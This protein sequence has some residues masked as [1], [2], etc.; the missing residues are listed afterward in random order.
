MTARARPPAVR[1]PKPPAL[2]WPGFA[3]CDGV[4][5]QAHLALEHA[6][7]HG[8]E[9]DFGLVPG[10]HPLQR[11]LLKSRPELLGPLVGVDENHCR[12]QRRRDHVHPRPQGHLGDESCG[13]RPRHGLLQIPLRIGELGAQACDRGVDAFDVRGVGEPRAFLLGPRPH[14]ALFRRF[15]IAREGIERPPTEATFL[16]NARSSGR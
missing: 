15:E 3:G 6:T 13:R 9:G 12:P 10:F 5:D 2:R 14:Q 4:Q 1:V 8:I 16:N 7:G 11:V